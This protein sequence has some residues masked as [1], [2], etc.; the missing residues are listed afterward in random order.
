MMLEE[1][2][3]AG[4]ARNV[5]HNGQS[6]SILLK[7]RKVQEILI[8]TKMREFTARLNRL[9]NTE[10]VQL[11]VVVEP[12]RLQNGEILP[13]YLQQPKAKDANYLKQGEI[14]LIKLGEVWERA[15]LM[16][17]QAEY[18]D[19]G[20]E[21]K[22]EI[23]QSGVIGV[24]F[25]GT[26]K[27]NWGVL[28]NEDL[29]LDYDRMS[30]QVPSGRKQRARLISECVICKET[31]MRIYPEERNQLMSFLPYTCHHMKEVS[32]VEAV[33]QGE[34][35]EVFTISDI[36]R[37]KQPR[38]DSVIITHTLSSGSSSPY[39]I[40][41]VDQKMKTIQQKWE[42]IQRVNAQLEV[43]CVEGDELENTS[44]TLEGV[45]AWA[46]QMGSELEAMFIR[47][48]SIRDQM[49]QLGPVDTPRQVVQAREVLEVVA[50]SEGI[51]TESSGTIRTMYERGLRRDRNEERGEQEAEANTDGSQLPL[52]EAERSL[53][54][55]EVPASP[56]VYRSVHGLERWE[57]P[58]VGRRLGANLQPEMNLQVGVSSREVMAPT[59]A[60]LSVRLQRE[61][62]QVIEE[63]T[64][65]NQ[66]LDVSSPSPCSFDQVRF[67]KEDVLRIQQSLEGLRKRYEQEVERMSPGSREGFKQQW[68]SVEGLILPGGVGVAYG[69]IYSKMNVQQTGQVQNQVGAPRGI[70]RLE[71]VALPRFSGKLE[72]FADFRRL[73]KELTNAEACTDVFLMVQL[74]ERI[75]KEAAGLLAG[76]TESREAW[77]VLE[78]RYGNKEQAILQAMHRLRA[79]KV[80]NGP[81]YEQV[82]NLRI[83]VRIAKAHLRAVGAEEELF[84]DRT[85]FA[86]LVNKI[87]FS[88]QERWH[89]LSTGL[90]AQR[91]TESTGERFS[92]WL[93]EEGRAATATRFMKMSVAYV[94]E[95]GAGNP[96]ANKPREG[97]TY[98]TLRA[99]SFVA[100]GG[101]G[102]WKEKLRT[103]EGAKEMKESLIKR[104]GPCVLCKRQ[105]TYI[106]KFLWGTG[107]WPSQRMAACPTFMSFTPTA[108][109]KVVEDEGG[110]GLCTSAT[111]VVRRCFL[112]DRGRMTAMD[113]SCKEPG[114]KGGVCGKMHH[115]LLHGSGNLYCQANIAEG[116]QAEEVEEQEVDGG[117][118]EADTFFTKVDIIDR[119]RRCLFEHLVVP[120]KA[121]GGGKV[122]EEIVLTDSAANTNFVTHDLAKELGAEG[123]VVEYSLKVV[124]SQ[125]RKRKTLAYKIAIIDRVGMEHWVFA[126]GVDTITDA[127]PPSNLKEARRMFPEAPAEVFRRPTGPVKVLLSMT[128]RHLHS[129]G[130]EQVGGLRLSPTPLG[131]GWVLT[132]LLPSHGHQA[133]QLSEE[134]WALMAGQKEAPTQAAVFH[135]VVAEPPE[136]GFL[137]AE[138]MGYSPP[139]MC[140][141]CRSCRLCEEKRTKVSFDD[142]MILERVEKEMKL[143]PG[144]GIL[145]AR[146]PWKPCATKMTDNYGQATK[147]QAAV[148][149][150]QL[151]DG[152]HGDYVEEFRKLVEKG[153]LRKLT[154][155]EMLLWQGPINYNALFCVTKDSSMST[156]TRIV[157]N[158]KQKNQHSGLSLNECMYQGPDCLASLL[159][160]LIHWRIVQASLIMDL[161]KAYQA[162]HTGEGMELHLRRVVFREDATKEWKIYAFTRATFGDLA[163]GLLLE[164][165]KRRAAK[166]G[167]QIDPQAARQ[168]VRFT[169]VDDGLPG[170]SDEDVDRMLGRCTDGV[171]DG[172]MGRILATC[173]LKAKFMVKTGD[174]NPEAAAPLGGKVLG[175]GY[176]LASDEIKMAVPMGQINPTMIGDKNPLYLTKRKVLS[177]VMS[178]FDPLGLLGPILLKGKIMLRELYGTSDPGWDKPLAPSQQLA[179]KRW[180]QEIQREPE[181]SFPRT[182]RPRGAVGSPSLVG[183]SDASMTA[184]CAVIYMVWEVEGN[185][186]GT[187]RILIA[188]GRVTPVHGMTIPRAELQAL[189]ILL[190]LASTVLKATEE[191][192][193]RVTFATDSRCVLAALHKPAP[194]MKPYFANRV[195]EVWALLKELGEMCQQI[196][197]PLFVP[198]SANPSDLGTREGARQADLGPDSV[199]QTG[200]PFLRMHRTHWPLK[201]VRAGD[202]PQSE[203]RSKFLEV[204]ALIT[205]MDHTGIEVKK[206]ARE[207]VER[208]SS[209]KTAQGALALV[210]RAAIRKDRTTI[211]SAIT[212][213]EREMSKKI[214]IWAH[215]DTARE[216]LA[217]GKLLSLGARQTRGFVVVDGRV[218][219]EDLARILGKDILPIIL[220]HEPLARQVLHDAHLEDHNLD[221]QYLIARARKEVWIPRA[222]KTAKAIASGCMHCRKRNK[223]MAKQVMGDMP[224]ERLQVA[225]PF[226]IAALD[227]FGPFWV[228]DVAQ[229]R[230]KFKTW[231][232]MYLCLATKAVAI[233]A[234]PGYSTPV[235][236]QTHAK[237]VSTYTPDSQPTKIY[238]DHGPQ[239]LSA[240]KG[241]EWE[242]IRNEV[243]CQLT[244]WVFTPKACSWR[245]GA[246]E[247]AIRSARHTLQQVI[248]TGALLDLH[249]L[250]SVFHQVA[251]ILNSRPISVRCAAPDRF[252]SITPSD[253]LLGRAARR[254]SDPDNFEPWEED[255]LEVAKVASKQHRLVVLWW[256][257]WLSQ[258][259]QDLVPRSKWTQA[260]RNI[261]VGDICH[262]AYHNK[263]GQPL[264]RLCK[265]VE[266][267]PDSRSNVRTCSVEFHNRDARTDGRVEYRPANKTTITTAVQRLA[268]M[269]PKEQQ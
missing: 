49:A 70:S 231:A 16:S 62:D 139:P 237:F 27:P 262:I 251:A 81:A 135:L 113:P 12:V 269:L 133:P 168:L 88:C 77:E 138:E 21:W 19:T 47:G 110:C 215:S 128:E 226:E 72:E 66:Q 228:K 85:I 211:G 127:N 255:D 69:R 24:A 18:K 45:Q 214:T 195:A 95:E 90:D 236:L 212:P 161:E 96:A 60:F 48:E 185:Q 71:R 254:Y 3:A 151:R 106:R 159:D 38:K 150:R 201:E 9:A 241:V 102:D 244:E 74:R 205:M 180:V 248:T 73:F 194:A 120:V 268:V 40:D 92:R 178:A 84:V 14:I 258:S 51:Q 174:P 243:G 126:L 163:A 17:K 107:E 98:T 156:K 209:W 65:L 34:P 75:P 131:C 182:T 184:T 204:E 242:Q 115:Q 79:T 136:V 221:P 122:Q 116:R 167:E 198:G 93:E 58:S 229:G 217:E 177:F 55:F 218:R 1:E 213:R 121:E 50:S 189:V 202:I 23:L 260:Q 157:S 219:G 146:Y 37:P 186:V 199:W 87:P 265:V 83:A 152:G 64:T 197:N 145:E 41:L 207:L 105:H 124:D 91:S 169:Y 13:Y 162:I 173:G 148:E 80:G 234:C 225:A 239:L 192:I 100:E 104:F 46:E 233:Y 29:A 56:L 39:T 31:N 10:E 210:L 82:E 119:T 142:R 94:R 170:G 216:A 153:S 33:P 183:F 52:P 144:R 263:V 36:P 227:M 175:V 59:I 112:A 123:K 208:C 28:R 118:M 15:K 129:H 68:K 6:T 61:R 179:W 196:D 188:K 252:H 35:N 11:P 253:I 89:L 25:L 2:G 264:F 20:Y 267:F 158:S 155:K 147:I 181:V 8:R 224:S 238:C 232:I 140:Q 223:R 42:K 256:K 30:P 137:E 250:D 149:K 190:R 111:H 78:A 125:Y 164:V 108:R 143:V 230:R 117:H 245:N 63:W 76:V 97:S 247:R 22:F 141:G 109:A 166:E 257:L 187:A 172:T 246:C 266:I 203:M 132:G 261:Q 240:A 130:G 134:V 160:V 4:G 26:G 249:Q 86:Q 200:P 259:F 54:D 7:E 44:L 114:P 5:R 67:W 57:G 171:Y 101:G 53:I 191:K 222:T 206:V 154:D 99:D 43:A 193:A 165:A 220:N 32:G 103:M 176:D 235:F